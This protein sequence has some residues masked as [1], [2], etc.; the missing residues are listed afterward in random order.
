MKRILTN[1]PAQKLSPTNELQEIIESQ[2]EQLIKL[3]STIEENI[4][5][6]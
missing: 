4:V 5:K 1:K 3:S 6:F 2:E